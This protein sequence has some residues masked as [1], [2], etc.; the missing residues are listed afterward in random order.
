MEEKHLQSGMLT[1]L[2]ALLVVAWCLVFLFSITRL[3]FALRETTIIAASLAVIVAEQLLAAAG[4][5]PQI[6]VESF[7]SRKFVTA[8]FR[9]MCGLLVILAAF[10]VARGDEKFVKPLA[11]LLFGG[12]LLIQVVRMRNTPRKLL[13]ALVCWA[14][15]LVLYLGLADMAPHGRLIGSL[16]IIVAIFLYSV[17]SERTDSKS[18]GAP[19][20]Q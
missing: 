20:R 11:F 17:S 15:A 9:R 16:L 13:P 4:K 7:F 8:T 14:G 18:T 5:N 6:R 19:G 1:A 2:S 10:E 12:L 3:S